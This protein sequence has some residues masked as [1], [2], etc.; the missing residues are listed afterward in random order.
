MLCIVDS[1]LWPVHV[2]F[3]ILKYIQAPAFKF[4]IFLFK[5]GSISHKFLFQEPN[6]MPPPPQKKTQFYAAKL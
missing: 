1:D 3:I 2:S 5:I 4:H 6:S